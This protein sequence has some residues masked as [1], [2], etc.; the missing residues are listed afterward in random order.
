M[1][2][3]QGY[4]YQHTIINIGIKLR[5]IAV[6]T[7]YI[8]SNSELDWSLIQEVNNR[9]VKPFIDKNYINFSLDGAKL[10]YYT[11]ISK[12]QTAI[13]SENKLLQEVNI[14]FSRLIVTPTC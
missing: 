6:N 5:Q 1:F 3:A 12:K 10:I 9:T 8:H 11:I 2:L 13:I 7:A 14:Y 4:T